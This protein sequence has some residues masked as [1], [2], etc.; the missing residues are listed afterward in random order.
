MRVI[1][2]E[3]QPP[4]KELPTFPFLGFY[5]WDVTD[6]HEMNALD[7]PLVW[8]FPS[9]LSRINSFGSQKDYHDE[10][11]S[12]QQRPRKEKDIIS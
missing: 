10:E 1:Q 8:D 4:V 6:R 3:V 9:F 7:S 5:S 2:R 11:T 12:I